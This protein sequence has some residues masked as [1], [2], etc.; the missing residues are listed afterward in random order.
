MY[1]RDSIVSHLNDVFLCPDLGTS[2][3]VMKMEKKREKI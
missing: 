2:E 3:M 1:V